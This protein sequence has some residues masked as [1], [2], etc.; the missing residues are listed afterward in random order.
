MA[1]GSFWN[2]D[3]PDKPWGPMDPDDVLDIPF[4]FSD[5]LAGQ[6]TSYASHVLTPAAGL[7]AATVS[8]IAG[9]VLVQVQRAAAAEL[10]VGDKY[11]VTCQLVAADGQKRSKTLY[12]KMK[13]L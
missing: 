3:N 9:V 2:V 4:D 12:L 13:E 7:Q 10:K 1:T 6:G 11:G 8:A 5:W